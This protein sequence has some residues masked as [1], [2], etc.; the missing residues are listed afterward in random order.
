MFKDS[1]EPAGPRAALTWKQQTPA[2]QAFWRIVRSNADLSRSAAELMTKGAF[3]AGM[4]SAVVY[5]FAFKGQK[6]TFSAQIT[7]ATN[8]VQLRNF[9]QTC[10][11]GVNGKFEQPDIRAYMPRVRRP[12]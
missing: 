8:A 5:T 9:L 12:F 7:G 10:L 3:S 1:F 11:N 4:A 6:R 2:E